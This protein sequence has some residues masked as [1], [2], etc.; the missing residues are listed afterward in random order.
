[1]TYPHIDPLVRRAFRVALDALSGSIVT[2]AAGLA[3]LGCAVGMAA[4]VGFD[5]LALR[6]GHGAR[7]EKA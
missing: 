1:M 6:L 4:S 5:A 7:R 3:L 2:F